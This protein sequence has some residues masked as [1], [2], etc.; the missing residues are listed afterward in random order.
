MNTET[1]SNNQKKSQRDLEKGALW[2]KK[3]KAGADFLSGYITDENNNKV[4]VVVFKNGFKKPGEMS[5]DYRVYL[6][7]NQLQ[8]SLPTHKSEKQISQKSEKTEKPPASEEVSDDDI[9]F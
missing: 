1:Q 4:N 8:S 7:D 9:P 5:P 6:S 2:L 3:S